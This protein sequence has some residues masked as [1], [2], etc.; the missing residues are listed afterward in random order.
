[1]KTH[2]CDLGVS[3]SGFRDDGLSLKPDSRPMCE[4]DGTLRAY[5]RE[6]NFIFGLRHYCGRGTRES[7]LWTGSESSSPSSPLHPRQKTLLTGSRAPSP[8]FHFLR[9]DEAGDIATW[10]WDSDA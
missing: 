8:S 5:C 4:M 6:R 3:T 10:P 1:M 9:L 2:W 7:G